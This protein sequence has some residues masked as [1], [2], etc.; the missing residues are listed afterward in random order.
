M[1]TEGVRGWGG[2][3]TSDLVTALIGFLGVL[4]GAA[5]ALF[6]ARQQSK[7]QLGIVRE[8]RLDRLVEEW[9]TIAISMY[10]NLQP[11][12]TGRE[13]FFD[14][15]HQLRVR[16]PLL[17]RRAKAAAPSLASVVWDWYSDQ[18]DLQLRTN[19][20]DVDG[21]GHP[22]NEA[23]AAVEDL[24]ASMAGLIHALGG[25]LEDPEGFEERAWPY[26]RWVEVGPLEDP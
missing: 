17:R 22:S 18:F 13:Y 12:P 21:S 15:W 2:L 9:M 14:R 6:V 26:R 19:F 16:L 23:R 25:W 11:G 3:D 7:T 1:G 10:D 5:V 24:R 4:V 8:E 20:D